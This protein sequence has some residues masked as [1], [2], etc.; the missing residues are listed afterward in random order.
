MRAT[1]DNFSFCKHRH[2]NYRTFKRSVIHAREFREV[3]LCGV[4]TVW[5]DLLLP[6]LINLRQFLDLSCVNRLLRINEP[7]YQID[8]VETLR[9]GHQQGT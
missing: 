8:E 6:R 9:F 1:Y 5:P 3:K 7:Q 2:V 4:P